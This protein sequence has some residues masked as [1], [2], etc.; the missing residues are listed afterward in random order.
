MQITFRTYVVATIISVFIFACK[1]KTNT[2]STSKEIQSFSKLHGLNFVAPPKEFPQ[3]PMPEVQN[4]SA[5]WIAVIPYGYTMPKQNKVVYNV[6]KWQWWGETPTGAKQTIKLAHEANIKVMLKPQVYFPRSWSGYLD[7]EKEEDWQQWES[8]YTKYIM[9]FVNIAEETNVEMFC[10]G[11][12]FKIS[13]TKREAFW[14]K[15]IAE[16]KK[17]YHGKL[18]Y[19][20]NWDEYAIVPF[21]DELDYIGINAYF[22]LINEKTPSVEHLQK[23]WQT[24]LNNIKITQE[25][26]QKPVIFTEYGYLTVDGCAYNSWEL[27]VKINSLAINEEAQSN[28]IE[29]LWKTCGKEPWWAGGFLWKWFPNMQGHEG[30]PEK[31]YTPQKKKGEHSLKECHL[32]F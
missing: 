17:A 16:I 23:A 15:L 11:T 32:K 20:S 1:Q 28:A 24:P 21:W 27:E 8:D 30:Y 9:T 26:F 22:P 10:I 3:N 14:R 13:I 19:A 25:K 4:V 18:T 7:F 31:D 5:D 12:E 6:E 29:A 2:V